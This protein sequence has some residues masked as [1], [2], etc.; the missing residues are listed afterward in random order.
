MN[1][2][3]ADS[4]SEEAAVLDNT[5]LT[6]PESEN[7]MINTM[8]ERETALLKKIDIN[9]AESE[10]RSGKNTVNMQETYTVYLIEIRPANAAEGGLPVGDSPWR[11]YS[12]FELLR[13]YLLVT[14]PFVVI[15]PL[16]EK[17]AEFVWH[18][19]SADNLDP[20]F[21]ERRRLGLE[22]FLIRVAS[23]S[24]LS[25][26]KIFY[27]FLTEEKGWREA[28]LETGFQDKADSRLKSLSATLR[29]K[30]PDKS[31]TDLKQYSDELNS[32]IS[33]LLRVRAK[34]ADRMYGVYKVHGNYGRIF[35]EWSAIEK[36]MGDGLQSA[37]HHMD[38]HSASVDDI[39]E[40]E[41]HY[42]DQ[43]K[44]YLFYTDALR[45]V[46]RK[47]ELIQYELEM[48]VLDLAS[49]KQQRE[50][51][52]TGAVR[53]FSLKGMSS[54]LFGQESPEQ[55]ESRLAA[56][57]Q[58]IQASEDAVLDKNQEC[59]EFMRMSW[60]EVKRFKEQKDR[61][62]REA[63]ISYAIMQISMCKKGIQVWSNAK[64]CFNKM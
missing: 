51:L 59:R 33:H 44:E 4:D 41:E 39:L 3:M 57:Q 47:H 11:R 22:N 32:A 24:V 27:Q 54:K 13:T 63:L 53:V 14:Y 43:L 12:E 17:R 58:S 50:E 30:N 62:L 5:D 35:S 64:E 45:S 25:K 42:A 9:V 55:R 36:E 56:L 10:K 40:E 28:V 8:V 16:P 60:E 38:T 48:A 18:K 2:T 21:V 52:T 37:G 1:R 7:N 19:L 23:H 6:S 15:P 31:F 49:K 20:D 46:C 34:V 29:V 61:E 26:D